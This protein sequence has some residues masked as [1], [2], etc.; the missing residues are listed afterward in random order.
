MKLT[1]FLI[2]L[3]L[4]LL[5]LCYPTLEIWHSRHGQGTMIIKSDHYIQGI[6]WLGKI[7]LSDDER[8]IAE[9]SP[10]GYLKFKENDTTMK[11]ESDLQGRISYTLYNGSEELPLNDSG[12]SFVACQIQKM[13]R[14]G[15][16]AED[17]AMKIYRKAGI[18]GLIAEL[19]RIRM[20]GAR[21]QYL[22]L[23][24]KSDSL[25]PADEIRLL[26]L[27][28]NSND[29]NERQQLL[30]RF[31]RES[32]GDSA[33]ASEWLIAVGNLDQAYVKKDLLLRYIGEDAGAGAGI[34]PDRFD[35]VL[36][37]TGRFGSDY[38]EQEVYK[39]LADVPRLRTHD[40]A[41]TLPWLSAVGKLNE[42]Y[43]KK[44]LLLRFLPEDSNAG[45]IVSVDEFD[46][47]IAVTRR[48]QNS[49]D[50][51]EVYKRLA[52]LPVK[53]DPEWAGLIRA[54]GGLN[55]DYMKTELMLKIAQKMPRTDSLRSAYRTAAKSIRED[56]DYGKVMRAL[57]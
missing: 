20:E 11:A 33:V 15:F 49:V 7:Q 51:Q 38:D 42:S 57:E 45:G 50:E 52:D 1:F 6:W 54:A 21:D 44:D 40:S 35:A 2:A 16:F 46:S 43:M 14:L 37:I 28:E 30:S 48:F 34:A 9:I 29:M 3:A 27:S 25:T 36:A 23:L 13:I 12:R 5:R 17:R 55:E 39:R 8:S 26:T 18:K 47:V 53:S 32:L 19:S 31:N 56:M 22:D 41:Y 4:V 10:G 24:F